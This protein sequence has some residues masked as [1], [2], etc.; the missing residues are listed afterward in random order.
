MKIRSRLNALER[1]AGAARSLS[2]LIGSGNYGAEGAELHA[3]LHALDAVRPFD[4]YAVESHAPAPSPDPRADEPNWM[5]LAL[6]RKLAV[7]L[8]RDALAAEH[9][10]SRWD[11]S[12]AQLRDPRWIAFSIAWDAVD[13]VYLTSCSDE[14]AIR[15]TRERWER[16]QGRPIPVI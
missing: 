11:P 7:K 9:G 16:A 2:Y 5:R 12:D 15:I 4:S 13:T 3:A 8:R 1:V 6:D 14:E 10:M